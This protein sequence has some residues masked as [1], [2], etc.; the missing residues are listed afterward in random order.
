VPKIIGGSLS[1]HRERTRTA[2]FNA[3]GELMVERG[4]DPITLADIAA[5]AGVGRTAVYNHFPDKEAMLLAYIA[6]E[7]EDYVAKLEAA[8]DGIDNPVEQVRTYVVRQAQ[9]KRIYR[10]T[11]GPDLRSVVSPQTRLQLRAHA[12]LVEDVLRRILQHGMATGVFAEQPLDT[13]VALVNACLSAVPTSDTDPQAT[14]ATVEFVLRAL[15]CPSAQKH[16]TPHAAPFQ[17]V[18]A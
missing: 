7:T 15:G 8:L 13:T 2:L 4:F 9:L 3:L 18:V 16:T 6:Y 12:E 14:T 11:P 1:E 17:A 5:R 10:V